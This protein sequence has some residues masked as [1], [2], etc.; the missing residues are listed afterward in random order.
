MDFDEVQC[1]ITLNTKHPKDGSF[2][3]KSEGPY[4]I[5]E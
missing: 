2:G 3:A 4:K 5:L 1:S